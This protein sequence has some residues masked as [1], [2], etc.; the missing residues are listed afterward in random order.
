MRCRRCWSD[1]WGCRTSPIWG[2]GCRGRGFSCHSIKFQLAAGSSWKQ[3]V[4][5]SKKLLSSWEAGIR[6][7]L[8]YRSTLWTVNDV[9]GK[10]PLERPR[11]QAVYRSTLGTVNDVTGKYLFKRPCE[12][13]VYRIKYTMDHQWC[14]RVRSIWKTPMRG[15]I[16]KMPLLGIFYIEEAVKTPFFLLWHH[17]RSRLYVP[18]EEINMARN[19]G[20]Y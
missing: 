11:E 1:H 17:W 7:S 3:K 14:H 6:Q 19:Y 18:W 15:F 10:Y 4:F 5:I 2:R 16:M 12:Q 9:T 13:A 20:W 8:V